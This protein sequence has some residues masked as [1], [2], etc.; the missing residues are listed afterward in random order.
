MTNDTLSL[1]LFAVQTTGLSSAGNDLSPEMKTY[2]DTELIEAARP[3]LVHQQ[4]GQKRSIPRGSGKT[5]E[6]RQFSALP[7]ALTP[8]TEGVTPN[9]S[10]L[11]VSSVTA[12][13][14]QYGDYITTSDVLEL[15]AI[16]PILLEATRL[17][18][19]QGGLT[20]DT[21][22]RNI[23]NAGTN[24]LYADKVSN[25]TATEVLKREDLTADCLLTPDVVLQASTIL[26]ASNVPTIDGAYVAIIHPE[27]A[28]DLINSKQF[29]DW[30]QYASPDELF[31]GEIGMIGNV[32][33]VK[34]SEAKI[35]K[36]STCPTVSGSSPTAYYSVY[37][38]LI[39]GANAYGVTS[40][41]GG[42]MEMIVQPKGSGGT[43]DPLKQ[44]A[45]IGWKALLTAKI[46]LEENMIRIESL[47]RFSAKSR[48]N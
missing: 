20:L 18:G 36:D 22:V 3:N 5:L 43:A 6:F 40:V 30:H 41:E 38:T 26:A 25:G 14:S 17:L 28:Y 2:Y 31:A 29:Q 33:F 19:A 48:A 39:F 21:V 10:K 11:D 45:S 37:S 16:D 46:L 7:K 9:G 35:W 34:S 8:L 27:V 12:T 15:T 13:V 23:I 4:F 1:Q 47:S 24:V 42:G 32:R 44:R